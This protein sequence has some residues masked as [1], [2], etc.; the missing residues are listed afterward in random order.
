MKK[1]STLSRDLAIVSL[2]MFAAAAVAQAASV[3]INNPSFEAPVAAS[4]VNGVT[5]GNGAS[6]DSGVGAIADWT[7][8]GNSGVFNPNGQTEYYTATG[9]AQIDGN[10]IAYSNGDT[11]SQTLSATLAANT[12][13]TL[14]LLVGDRSDVNNSGTVFSYGLYDATT[15]TLLAGAVNVT[16]AAAFT[17]LKGTFINPTASYTSGLSGVGDT[18]EIRLNANTVQYDF[19]NVKLDASSAV[20][21]PASAWSGMALLGGLATYGG[22]KRIR[23]QLA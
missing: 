2:S 16:E 12:T 5:L 10:Q 4:G 21:L 17:G 14:S 15:N 11:I 8:G 18:L 7:G 23:R 19:D 3:T 1:I 9:L 20:P 13:Y 6:Y 22:I